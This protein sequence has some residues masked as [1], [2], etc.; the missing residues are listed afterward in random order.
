MLIGYISAFT[1]SFPFLFVHQFCIGFSLYFVPS[2]T[3]IDTYLYL[4]VWI[5]IAHGTSYM[6]DEQASFFLYFCIVFFLPCLL[7]AEPNLTP[8][9]HNP[10]FPPFFLLFFCQANSGFLFPRYWLSLLTV[11]LTHAIISTIQMKTG[12]MCV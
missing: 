2:T 9:H 1:P 12:Q 3:G 7:S 11:D 4:I 8:P 10:L 5:T 6:E